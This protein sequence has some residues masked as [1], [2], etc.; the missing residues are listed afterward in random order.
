MLIDADVEKIALAQRVLLLTPIVL[1]LGHIATKQTALRLNQLGLMLIAVTVS[2]ALAWKMPM[3]RIIRSPSRDQI[4]ELNAKLRRLTLTVSDK[5][6]DLVKMRSLLRDKEV[7][8]EKL[9]AGNIELRESVKNLSA[10]QHELSLQVKQL[11]TVLNRL[12]RTEEK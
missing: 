4:S 6:S 8:I 10:V 2:V 11:K 7:E 12:S 1:A 3:G 5:E 9:Q